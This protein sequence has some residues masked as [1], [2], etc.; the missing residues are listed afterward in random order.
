MSSLRGEFSAGTAQEGNL[1]LCGT[2][3]RA[4]SPRKANLYITS[5]KC[6][7]IEFIPQTS[8]M[9][10][11]HGHG[12]GVISMELIRGRVRWNIDA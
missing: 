5:L 4:L 10:D 6:T 8:T 3:K 9:N 7:E 1:F 2:H 12:Y 11:F